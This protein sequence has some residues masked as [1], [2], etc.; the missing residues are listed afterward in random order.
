MFVNKATGR[1]DAKAQRKL[2]KM[3][4][5]FIS[6]RNL[7]HAAGAAM[8]T[9]GVDA[10]AGEDDKKSF[11]PLRLCVN[12]F[13]FLASA[14]L[15][16]TAH[17]IPQIQHWQTSN[18]VPVYF[19]QAKDLP[20]VDLRLTFDAGSARDGARPGTSMLTNGL[21]AEG[22]GG[23]TSQQLAEQFDAVGARFGNG[24]SRDMAW[25]QLRSLSDA[26][27]LQPALTT[28]EKIL[29][30]PDFPQDAWQREL[31]RLQFAVK[32]KQQSP[33]AIA[34]EAFNRALYGNHPYAM[35]EEGTE[36]SLAALSLK[37]LQM[38]Y[39]RYYVA[40]N[41]ILVMVGDL[42]RQ[43]AESL[44]QNL[45]A[46]LPTGEKP[47]AI[48]PVPMLPEAKNIHIN[49]PSQ[50]SHVL[51]GQPASRRDDPD[52]F[53]LYVA[54]HTLG[55]SGF[56][57]RLMDEVREKRGLA[58]SVYSYFMPM[59]EYGPFELGLQTRSDQT[60][61]ALDVANQTLREYVA[62]GPTEKELAAAIS[63]ITGG[64]ALRI[65]SNS[66]L[67]E[68]LAMI[69][70][71]HLPLDYLDNFVERIRAVNAPAIRDA[72]KRHIDPERMVTVVVGPALSPAGFA[73]RPALSPSMGE[74]DAT[75]K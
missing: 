69:S 39:K 74:E 60:Q 32:A 11:A 70:F 49:F 71:Y 75:T 6:D 21:L 25:L 12:S 46:G 29:N 66:K 1:K 3:L 34:D 13:I 5:P 23:Q 2:M 15:A 36:Q 27:Y 64:F 58:Y 26:R 22:A 20:M 65:D 54:N 37:D 31:K 30:K 61:Q 48:A 51:I 44:A 19:I 38:F 59:R 41:A 72:L 45:L 56:A 17:A 57:S 28:L 68:Y 7:K 10:H 24:V 67:A 33:A 53:T 52:Y 62:Q 43:Q 8:N 55:G 40:R 4:F 42:D 63:N 9:F 73:P 35:P 47:A 18:G 14:L 16:P 50:Q